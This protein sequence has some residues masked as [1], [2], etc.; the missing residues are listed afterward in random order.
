MLLESI[1]GNLEGWGRGVK[2][3]TGVRRCEFMQLL[4][5]RWPRSE[6]FCGTGLRFAGGRECLG[7]GACAGLKRFC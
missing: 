5:P 7:L 1:G 6:E 2:L 3:W 4:R